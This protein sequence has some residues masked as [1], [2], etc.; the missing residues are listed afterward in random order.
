[1]ETKKRDNLFVITCAVYC[2]ILVAFVLIRLAGALGAFDFLS[3]KGGDFVFSFLSQVG[4]MFLV[5]II[6][7]KIYNK[8]K[9]QENISFADFVARAGGFGGEPQRGGCDPRR[10]FGGAGN[11]GLREVFAHFGFKKP[12]ANIVMWSIAI[13]VILYV[14]NMFISAFFNGWLAWF[15]HRGA[16]QGLTDSS[17]TGF[18]GFLIMMVLIACLPALCEET[19]H[20]GL[21]LRGFAKRL[22]VMRAVSLSALL[23]GLIHLNI[24]QFFYAW[25]VGYYMA[26]MVM[27][28]RT[29][30]SAIIIHFVN[31]GIS[32]YLTFAGDNGWVLANI[33]ET[34]AGL[35][36]GNFIF[37][38]AFF[39]SIYFMIVAIIHKFARELFIQKFINTENPPNLFFGRGSSAIKYYLSMIYDGQAKASRRNGGVAYGV[40]ASEPMLPLERALFYGMIFLGVVVTGMTLWWGFM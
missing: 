7:I 37:T 14:F 21:L 38:I 4:V 25:I 15:G 16:T 24:V 5:P 32:V 3:D 1:M 34:I 6:G 36:G 31:N 19:A 23:F 39:I 40:K 22:G 17:F 13:G 8:R 35:I 29:I 12:T 26:L 18:G 9:V 28:T 11:G 33:M 2:V 30:W 10:E 20:R 27:A